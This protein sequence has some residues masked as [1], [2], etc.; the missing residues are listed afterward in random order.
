MRQLPT[1]PLKTSFSNDQ[2]VNA[3]TQLAPPTRDL[4][5]RSPFQCGLRT[6]ERPVRP[7]GRHWRGICV[8][9]CIVLTLTL[10]QG[11]QS[12]LCAEDQTISQ[13]V[14]TSWTARD[15][16]PQN[17]NTLAQT[18]DGTLWLGTRDG[19]YSF[20]GLKFS[21]SNL[22]PRKNVC[23]LC[24]TREGDLW[25]MRCA[26]PASRIRGGEAKVFDRVDAGALQS[27]HD[28]QQDSSGTIW[29]II[30]SKKLVRLGPDGVWHF[31]TGPKPDCDALGN[32]FVDSLGTQWIVA[33]TV[34]YRR[35]RDEE[36]FRSTHL[37][38]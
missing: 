9:K 20:D 3:A 23:H 8:L 34:L 11:V 25:V 36:N 18:A 13:M 6:S 28:L 14:H 7:P 15:G 38:V 32:L 29:A 1:S 33:D 22:V 10:C 26:G 27:I 2:T 35:A 17:I 24:S 12:L 30:N 5:K 37:T 31:A 19:L 21:V 4:V 16:A